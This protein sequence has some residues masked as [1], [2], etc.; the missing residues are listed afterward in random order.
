MNTPPENAFRRL[1]IQSA[2][3]ARQGHHNNATLAFV[4]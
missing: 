4:T 1:I 2:C 3:A